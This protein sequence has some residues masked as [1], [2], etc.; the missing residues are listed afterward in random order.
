M[1]LLL[2][3][4]VALLLL[5]C[6][7]VVWSPAHAHSVGLSSVA[8]TG[9]KVGGACDAIVGPAAVYCSEGQTPAPVVEAA[10]W[11]AVPD[12]AALLLFS[13]AAVAAAIGLLST[14]GRRL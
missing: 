14:A 3:G 6:I 7:A 10:V 1:R 5:V 13:T 4:A 11:P 8:V 9:G 2:E 12:R